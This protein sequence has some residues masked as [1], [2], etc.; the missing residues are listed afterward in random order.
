MNKHPFTESVRGIYGS[1]R[2]PRLM[3][4]RLSFR[5]VT[6]EYLGLRLTLREFIVNFFRG[7]MER[8]YKGLSILTNIFCSVSVVCLLS[9]L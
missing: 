4:T 6:K 2:I 9:E 1:L 8:M 7:C 5:Q 3:R